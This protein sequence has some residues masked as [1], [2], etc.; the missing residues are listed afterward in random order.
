M[1]TVRERGESRDESRETRG[2]RGG[3]GIGKTGVVLTNNRSGKTDYQ[4]RE[5]CN[6]PPQWPM[7]PR[8][9][10]LVASLCG[11]SSSDCGKPARPNRRL[12]TRC[13]TWARK[14]RN[15]RMHRWFFGFLALICRFTRAGGTFCVPPSAA[16]GR[17]A[18][19]SAWW[20]CLR[21]PASPAP[22]A[23]RRRRSKGAWRS[24]GAGCAG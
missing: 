11:R 16:R 10:R 8:R 14:S 21:G 5:F 1:V 19:K 7:R 20:R 15:R 9:R 17:R 2:E 4:Q 18:C 23:G 13:K 24:C 12:N 22:D 6:R 3:V